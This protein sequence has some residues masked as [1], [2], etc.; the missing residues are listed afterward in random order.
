M[1][2]TSIE[3][4]KQEATDLGL[5]V[6]E[7]TTAAK[8]KKQ[9]DAYYASQE[10]SGPELIKSV[11]ESTANSKALS[12]KETAKVAKR[13]KRIA[14]A[15]KTKIVTIIDNDQ[16]VNN[17]TTTCT[18]NCSNEFFDLGTVVL[19]LNERIEV[20]IG[21]INTLRE[22][23]I[24]LHVRDPKSGLSSVRLRPRYSISEE[25]VQ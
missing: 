15:K 12:D 7:N 18:V 21:H 17:N 16:R 22:I 11:Q 1:S 2:T 5:A 24:P 13:N 6:S 10:T 20:A 14:E 4:L 8:L 25:S 23:Q 3:G 9:I 19:P